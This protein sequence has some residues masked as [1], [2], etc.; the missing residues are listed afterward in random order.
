MP[1]ERC[2]RCNAVDLV[3]IS[4][5]LPSVE[6]PDLP[7]AWESPTVD[8]MRYAPHMRH[9]S[10]HPLL[11]NSPSSTQF[12]CHYVSE[13]SSLPL[14]HPDAVH[15]G[16][17]RGPSEPPHAITTGGGPVQ[18]PNPSNNLDA[19]NGSYYQ[20]NGGSKG[21]VRSEQNHALDN[22]SSTPRAHSNTVL[23]AASISLLSDACMLID[24]GSDPPESA[25][26][27]IL[28]LI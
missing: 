22:P 24:V 2:R 20:G 21:P 15:P 17:H 1:G 13:S 28:S 8:N 27:K 19:A 6:K 4:Q 14:P 12:A 11:V 7:G 18:N 3:C 16:P 9:P 23:N 5:D 25:S 26:S 10:S